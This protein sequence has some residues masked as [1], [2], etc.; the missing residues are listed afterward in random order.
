MLHFL[1]EHR[2]DTC[3]H[4]HGAKVV[5]PFVAKAKRLYRK[6]HGIEGPGKGKGAMPCGRSS[7]F[8]KTMH[9]GVVRRVSQAEKHRALMARLRGEGME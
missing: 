6:H 4:E 3:N 1:M 5:I 2:D 7:G 9:N 8:K